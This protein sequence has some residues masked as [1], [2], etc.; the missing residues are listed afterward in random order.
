M[1]DSRHNHAHDEGRKRYQ[2]RE[3]YGK[4]WPHCEMSPSRG[5]LDL[6]VTVATVLIACPAP[7]PDAT[8]REILERV[9]VGFAGPD[10]QR[11]IDRRHE[12]LAVADLAG[13]RASR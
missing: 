12:Y 13:A 8:S 11:M 6:S 9:A 10:P 1:P 4:A 3:F 5:P 7:L 2:G